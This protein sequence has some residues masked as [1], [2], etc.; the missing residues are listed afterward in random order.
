MWEGT[1]E[2]DREDA[3]LIMDMKCPIELQEIQLINGFGAFQIKEFDVYGSHNSSGP[4]NMLL[5]GT[6]DPDSVEVKYLIFILSSYFLSFL[7]LL[8]EE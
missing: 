1:K 7:G 5:E 6:L 4:W 2:N 3:E 8:C